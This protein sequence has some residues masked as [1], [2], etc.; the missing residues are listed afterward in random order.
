MYSAVLT[1]SQ[2]IV[3]T[4]YDLLIN[5]I[6]LLKKLNLS[7]SAEIALRYVPGNG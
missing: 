6:L 2:L 3:E 5:L 1:F 7:E 4:V